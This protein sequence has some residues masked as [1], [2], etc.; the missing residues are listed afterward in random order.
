MKVIAWL[1]PRELTV[2]F[3]YCPVNCG[4]QTRN[5]GRALERVTAMTREE[6]VWIHAY[7]RAPMQEEMS[8]VQGDGA[9]S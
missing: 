6:Q 2:V 3:E 9:M 7:I 5:L 4:E 8:F 1:N